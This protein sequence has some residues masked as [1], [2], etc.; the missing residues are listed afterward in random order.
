MSKR[1]LLLC[2]ILAAVAVAG[3]LVLYMSSHPSLLIWSV[4]KFGPLKL[5]DDVPVGPGAYTFVPPPVIPTSRFYVSV[6]QKDLWCVFEECCPGC[7][8]IKE[9]G[10]WL[11][12]EDTDQ[13]VIGE[14]F[15]LRDNTK[16]KSIIVI[17]NQDAKIVGIY[18]NKNIDDLFAV[19]KL[20][21]DLVGK[22]D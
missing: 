1:T 15:G 4:K 22:L 18:P 20:H 11:Q 21:S 12:G 2:L 8:R 6:V 17:G 16:V 19:L 9:L 3:P 13:P 5:G 10:G 14:I 7:A